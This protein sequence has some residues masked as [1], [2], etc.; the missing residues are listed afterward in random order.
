MYQGGSSSAGGPH[1][2]P[3]PQG[4]PQACSACGHASPGLPAQQD[5]R[6]LQM[7]PVS[8][9]G[10][11]NAQLVPPEHCLPCCFQW[12]S[13]ALGDQPDAQGQPEGLL[14][15]A[16]TARNAIQGAQER[17]QQNSAPAPRQMMYSH[18]PCRWQPRS[19]SAEICQRCCSAKESVQ[20]A[21]SSV[22]HTT[23]ASYQLYDSLDSVSRGGGARRKEFLV[24]D[25]TSGRAEKI[26]V[27][28]SGSYSLTPAQGTQRN[29]LQSLAP[30][31][32]IQP[33]G[34]VQRESSSLP[35]PTQIP[36]FLQ[37]SGTRGVQIPQQSEVPGM[38]QRTANGAAVHVRLPVPSAL[39][40]Q[41]STNPTASGNTSSSVAHVEHQ[42]LVQDAVVRD[43]LPNTQP[44]AASRFQPPV[45]KIGAVALK[46]L[47]DNSPQPARESFGYI[48]DQRR[49]LIMRKHHQIPNIGFRSLYDNAL[50][51]MQTRTPM[52]SDEAASQEPLIDVLPTSVVVIESQDTGKGRKSQTTT[53]QVDT[54]AQPQQ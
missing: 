9:I 20:P 14:P 2:E 41:Q 49:R 50:D 13:K 44:Q 12:E 4:A 17:P 47:Q 46:I 7:S 36:P 34:T 8:F 51:Y 53:T 18:D 5:G 35:P 29:N 21:V 27:L 42:P 33:M 6:G 3:M 32:A 26:Q 48:Y 19:Y 28:Q 54:L 16:A 30:A 10:A 40:Q 43:S 11:P 39:S 45:T 1:N 22:P 31:Q 24:V 52:A 25:P 23:P 15:P 37:P 38:T